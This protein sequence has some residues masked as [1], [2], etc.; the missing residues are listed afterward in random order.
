LIIL[1][2]PFPVSTNVYYRH[3]RGRTHISS[4]GTKY[5][6]AVSDYVAEN[7]LIAPPGRLSV[8]VSLFP[9]NKIKRDIDNFGGKSLLD[10][11]TYSGLIEDDSLVDELHIVRR[12]VVKGGRCT[13][14]VLQYTHTQQG[15]LT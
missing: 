11:L 12:D 14:I 4:A 13:V 10:A 5:R 3:N 8:I 9:P 6:I 2:L 7:K 15:V 1:N